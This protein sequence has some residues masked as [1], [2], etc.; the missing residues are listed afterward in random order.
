[1]GSEYSEKKKTPGITAEPCGVPCPI[2]RGMRILGGKWKA[3]ILWHLKDEPVRFN[4]LTRQ[5]DGASK[6]M[7]NQRLTEMERQG[8]VI[9]TVLKEKPI[10]VSYR[11]STEGRSALHILEALKEWA[12]DKAL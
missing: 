7:I 10:A 11:I 6:K 5:L 12:L 3:S 4:E 2:E 9:R 1:M 8:L